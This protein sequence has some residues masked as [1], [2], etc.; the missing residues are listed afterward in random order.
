MTGPRPVRQFVLKVHGR[1]N[2][3]CDYCYVYEMGDGSWRDRPRAM[4]PG[5]ADAAVDRVAEHA[6]AHGLDAVQVVLHGGEPL[7]A[8]V[9]ALRRVLTRA[10]DRVPAR[11]GFAVQT[12]GLLLDTAFLDL[13]AEFGVRV[14]V[15]LDGTAAGHDHHRR[16]RSG[17]GT[18]AA[19]TERLAAL[20][21]PYRHIFGGLL[22]V[23]D[24]TRA[25]LA[26]HTALTSFAPPVLDYLLPHGT[27]D[28]PPP[29][30]SPDPTRT[31]YGDWLVTI[32][33]HWYT[34]APGP[35]SVRLFDALLDLL[36][37]GESTVEG[38][39]TDPSPQVVVDTDGGIGRSDILAATVPTAA[40]TGLTV[41]R[42]PFDAALAPAPPVCPTCAACPLLRVCGGGQ[43]AHRHRTG[44]GLDNPS[45]YCPDLTR[46][47]THAGTRL[48]ADL[49]HLR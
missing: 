36:L 23:V 3:A 38:L 13:F 32:F 11:V 49:E 16:T 7:L 33:D 29:G 43:P 19:V 34:A 2:L 5:T 40:A 41:H 45:V 42:D 22:C 27:W 10:R 17:H 15:S 46:L 26:T 28:T 24:P 6:A 1:C 25:P 9:A 8:G 31:P 14:G 4:A 35:T 30:R 12:N 18:H 21:G 48:T 39:G 47:I 20:T 37:G 44:S